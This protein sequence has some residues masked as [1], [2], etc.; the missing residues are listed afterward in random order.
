MIYSKAKL[1]S[2][3][4]RLS[5]QDPLD[6]IHWAIEE[7]ESVIAT[8]HFGPHEA[9]ILHHIHKVKADLP[10][11]CID[12]GYNTDQTYQVAQQ[13]IDTLKLNVHFYTPK[14]TV[15]R[16]EVALGGVP[17]LLDD[18]EH[19]DF[20]DEVKLEPFA[21][22]FREQQPQLWLTSLRKEQT[23][24]RAGLDILVHDQRFKCL[25]VSPFFH[26][27]KA[28]MDAYL[29][30]QQLPDVTDYYDPTK[31]LEHRECGLHLG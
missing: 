27:A 19:Q 12:H 30:E 18:T 24:H 3:N 14:V 16:R 26:W 9:V 7:H 20:V 4:Y 1:E 22:A 11:I 10:I 5:Q 6:V 17:I 28:Q 29:A 31:V 15:R 8:T 2:L 21:R 13:L 25:K 23:Q